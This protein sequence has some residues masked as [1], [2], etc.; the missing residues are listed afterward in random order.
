MRIVETIQRTSSDAHHADEAREEL[1]QL[2]GLLTRG[3]TSK[4]ID[5]IKSI[6]QRLSHY[7]DPPA[8]DRV[9]PQ[10]VRR[11]KRARRKLFDAEVALLASRSTPIRA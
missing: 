9:S 1:Q 10:D 3:H 5:A 8:Q 6:E 7:V 11:A 2:L 4:A